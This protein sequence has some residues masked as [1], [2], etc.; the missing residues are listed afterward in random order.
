MYGEGEE[1]QVGVAVPGTHPNSPMRMVNMSWFRT[2]S[3]RHLVLATHSSALGERH[4]PAAITLLRMW[5]ISAYVP[6][7][8]RRHGLMQYL[9]EA[10]E[11]YLTEKLK[12]HV[13]LVVERSADPTISFVRG[14][15]D[16]Q[17]TASPSASTGGQLPDASETRRDLNSLNSSLNTGGSMEGGV[18]IKLDQAPLLPGCMG[19]GAIP[20]PSADGVAADAAGRSR[21]PRGGSGRLVPSFGVASPLLLQLTLTSA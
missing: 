9:L 11:Q 17:A 12:R 15:F 14:T 4:N 8:E 16:R 3:V 6:I 7:L 21:E 10:S 2:H 1:V 18:L 20:E 13:K 19:S 5:L